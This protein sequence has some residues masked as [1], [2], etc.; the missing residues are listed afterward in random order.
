L[1]F[2]SSLG[3]VTVLGE[4]LDLWRNEMRQLRRSA[5]PLIVA[6]VMFSVTSALA[7]TLKLLDPGKWDGGHSHIMG[8]VYVGPY[9]A[10]VG[11]GPS[12]MVICDDYLDEVVPG[13]SWTV[14]TNSYPSA[15]GQFTGW[16]KSYDQD[17]VWSKLT[18]AQE[19][20]AVFYL[21]ALMMQNLSNPQTVGEIQWALWAITDPGLMNKNGT[22]NDTHG[23]LSGY[24]TCSGSGTCIDSYYLAA[25]AH[26]GT[27]NGTGSIFTPVPKGAGQEYLNIVTPEPASLTLLGTGLLILAGGLR[28]KFV[29]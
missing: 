28:K 29:R 17:G 3:G 23:N 8:G 13:H 26:D 5:A 9:D 14:N 4:I 11:G 10:T 22:L 20:N 27:Q 18:R 7:S 1:Q 6:F 21:A 19:Y 24:E 15:Y 12:L 2:W 16:S 25:L